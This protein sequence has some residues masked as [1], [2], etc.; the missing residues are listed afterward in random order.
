MKI[1]KGLCCG[2]KGMK[3]SLEG[4]CWGKTPEQAFE[5]IRTSC[6]MCHLF[7]LELYLEQAR[8]F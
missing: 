4:F 8:P 2:N 1:K 5:G 7:V 3:R 6:A